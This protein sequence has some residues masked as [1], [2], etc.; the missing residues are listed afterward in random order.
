VFGGFINRLGLAVLGGMGGDGNIDGG[1]LGAEFAVAFYRAFWR[2]D[3]PAA[4]RAAEQYGALMSQLIRP[5]WSGALAS[6]QAQIKAAMNIL[7]QPG[8]LPRPPILPLDDAADLSALRGILSSAGLL[9]MA[10]A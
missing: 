6:P 3:L 10:A 5:D 7:G 8:G 1:G 2:G 9:R 4:E